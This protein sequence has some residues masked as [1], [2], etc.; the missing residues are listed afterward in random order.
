MALIKPEMTRKDGGMRRG[1]VDSK[2]SGAEMGSVCVP[3]HLRSLTAAV[4]FYNIKTGA[5]W[6][7]INRIIHK[8]TLDPS[9][10]RGRIQI[11]LK[12]KSSLL[13]ANRTAWNA[14]ITRPDFARGGDGSRSVHKSPL[15]QSSPIG[16]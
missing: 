6:T 9:T 12:D 10:G 1:E 2:T 11:L 8:D 5:G 4:C 3:P 7:V 13:P 16:R 14:E 15:R